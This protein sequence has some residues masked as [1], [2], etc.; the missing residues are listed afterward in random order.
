[1]MRNL[2]LILVAFF[3]F[4]L[5]AQVILSEDF[6]DTDFWE[7][8]S[9]YE[10]DPDDTDTDWVL[11]DSDGLADANDRPQNWALYVDWLWGTA[12]EPATDTNFVLGSS[13]WLAGFLP[14]N[15]NY[16]ILPPIE[17]TGS[18]FT[19]SWKSAPI[20]GPRYADG[21]TIRVSTSGDNV[22]D[23]FTDIL[24]EAAE[25]TAIGPDASSDSPVSD[26]DVGNYDWSNG[27]IHADS[28]TLS[29][30]F[31]DDGTDLYDH[32]LEP[33]TVSLADYVG[34]TIYIAV[35]HD[36]DD[37]NAIAVD[38]L[39]VEGS[40]G[41]NDYE[42]GNLVSFFPNPVTNDLNMTFTNMITDGSVFEVYDLNGKK[43]MNEVIF[44]ESNPTISID[45]SSLTSGLY[46]VRFIV[47]GVATQSTSIVKM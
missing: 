24:F 21:Y 43:I 12:N 22:A 9:N 38:D 44:P 26:L 25:M 32:V 35:V 13:S 14:G 47:D 40:V 39:L 33:H 29:E 41:V 18:D 17:V 36:S 27:Y 2:L 19:F 6:Q 10:I 5:N 37:D 7:D 45:W 3:T 31:F 4:G 8:D 46:S 20:Q 11:F 42:L 30:W 34:Q 1:M 15:L 16:L 28:Y 23:D